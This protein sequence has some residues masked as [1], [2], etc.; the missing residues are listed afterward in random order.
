M[1]GNSSFSIHK[2][3]LIGTQASSLVYLLSVAALRQQRQSGVVVTG[4][5]WPAK[6]EMFT[7]WFFTEKACWRL[8]LTEDQRC[9]LNVSLPIL[10][11]DY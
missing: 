3:S 10:T 5:H 9:L 2:S 4:T 11:P 7:V 8:R 1:I 6:P